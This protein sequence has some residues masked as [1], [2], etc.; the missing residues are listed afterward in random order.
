MI[1]D[2][3]YRKQ[4]LWPIFLPLKCKIKP[5]L[6]QLTLWFIFKIWAHVHN[7]TSNSAESFLKYHITFI[8]I[9]AD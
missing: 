9:D 3:F 6:F 7:H 8:Y 1:E 5:R 2:F 4:G